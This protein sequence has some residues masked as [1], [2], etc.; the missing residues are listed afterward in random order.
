MPKN[1]RCCAKAVVAS[2]ATSVNAAACFQLKVIDVSL[3]VEGRPNDNARLSASVAAGV[4]A[5][6]MGLYDVIV[7]GAGV[8]G[9]AVAWQLSLLGAGRVLV[10]DRGTIGSG[11]TAQS[12]GILRTHYS[13][14]ENVE[15]ARRSWHV[16]EHFA[17]ALG[18]DEASAGLV[19]CGY[20]IAAPDGPKLRALA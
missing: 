15:L 3:S 20:L 4:Y 12:S 14:S 8:V 10:L 18:D 1:M 5:R 11:T 17:E 16:F 19:K 7:I 2:A 9:T 13:V 6:A